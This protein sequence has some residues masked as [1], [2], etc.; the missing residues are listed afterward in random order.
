MVK[1]VKVIISPPLHA[2]FLEFSLTPSGRH[3]HTPLRRTNRFSKS[4]IPSA[5]RLLNSDGSHYKSGFYQQFLYMTNGV[6]MSI[7]DLFYCFL[8]SLI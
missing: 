8:F 5:I 7:Y 1:K 2:L 3:H 4:F 6:I